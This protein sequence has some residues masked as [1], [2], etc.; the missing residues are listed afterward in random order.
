MKNMLFEI[1]VFTCILLVIWKVTIGNQNAEVLIFLSKMIVTPLKKLSNSL[2]SRIEYNSFNAL[3]P[4]LQ[5]N[6]H[7]H[8]SS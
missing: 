4:R 2:F 7:F 3:F 6:F 5:L 1:M 8:P